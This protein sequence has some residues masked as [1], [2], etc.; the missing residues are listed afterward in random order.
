MTVIET[1]LTPLVRAVGET[2]GA[3]FAS[4]HT[5]AGVLLLC[6]KAV[7]GF[8]G[9]DRVEGLTLDDGSIVEADLVVLGVG[10]VPDVEWLKSSGLDL[11]DGLVCD[12]NLYAGRGAVFGAGDAVSWLNGAGGRMRSQQWTTAS[13]QGRHLG[14]VLVNG[15]DSVGPF[16]HDMYFWSDQYGVRIQS[17]GLLTGEPVVLHRQA[18]PARLVAAYRRGAAVSGAVT[19]NTPREFDRLRKLAQQSAPWDQVEGFTT[20]YSINGEGVA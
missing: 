15:A 8:V 1:T 17:A 4:L 19:I 7:T 12:A 6:G 9:A 2:I 18:D 14:R 11:S 16:L 10:V 20:S 3:E 5:R 13:D